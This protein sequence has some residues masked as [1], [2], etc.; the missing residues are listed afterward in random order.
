M[1]SAF[2][3][4]ARTLQLRR[5]WRAG[6]QARA[7]SNSAEPAAEQAVVMR[8]ARHCLWRARAFTNARGEH[9]NPAGIVL[10]HDRTA[11]EQLTDEDV[12]RVAAELGYSETAFVHRAQ[13]QSGCG[14]GE[15]VWVR[16]ATPA[17]H[18]DFCGHATV[19]VFGELARGDAAAGGRRDTPWLYTMRHRVLA[20]SE[21]CTR[22]SWPAVSVSARPSA[23]GH[24]FVEMEQALPSFFDLPPEMPREVAH[25]LGVTE[26]S[27]SQVACVS[28]GLK[29]VLVELHESQHVAS[30]DAAVS[31]QTQD[32]IGSVCRKHEAVGYHVWPRDAI[33]W[34]PHAMPTHLECSVKDVRNFAPCWGIAE[35]NATGSSSGAMACWLARR[36]IAESRRSLARPQ[37]S[38][39][40]QAGRE[41]CGV[42]T[43]DF[44]FEQGAAMGMPSEISASVQIEPHAGRVLSVRVGGTTCRI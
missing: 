35:E 4:A 37:A 27:I 14:A 15:D 1:R 5:G 33:C 12:V 10:V 20:R 28:T 17:A 7:C 36:Y 29:D 30:L 22:E 8:A 25:S 16:F 24:A 40:Q 21:G 3:A 13:G 11:F 32:K 18:I 9:G 31:P 43:I 44:R 6:G 19:A 34:T 42:V 38:F 26:S 39:T 41:G 2:V 23:K